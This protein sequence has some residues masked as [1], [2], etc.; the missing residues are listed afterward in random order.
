[1]LLYGMR[2]GSP[3][4]LLRWALNKHYG[5]D[6]LPE[7]QLGAHG[8]PYFPALPWVHFNLSHSG[9][10]SLCALSSAPVGVDIECVRP[11]RETLPR[12]ALTEKEYAR[13]C[14]EGG[15]WPAFFA[16]WTRREAWCKYTGRGLAVSRGQDAP[17]G[18][19]FASYGGK[20]WRAAVCGEEAPP[21]EIIW[22][23]ELS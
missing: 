14:A 23:E 5:L 9:D 11:R 10:Y 3:W 19:R 20:D 15:D 8:K 16:Q 7:V 22:L 17:E 2:R 1:M 18:L 4:D 12:Y 21:A 6:A 13:Y